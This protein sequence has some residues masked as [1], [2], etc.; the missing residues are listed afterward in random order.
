MLSF[1]T[2]TIRMGLFS[3]LFS[4]RN[5][6]GGDQPAKSGVEDYMSFIRIY[7]QAAMAANLG[8]TNIRLVPELAMF[9]RALKVPTVNN[10]L[11]LGEKAKVRKIMFEQYGMGEDFFDKIDAS[12][13][14]GCKNPQQIQ[15]YTARFQEFLNNLLTMITTLMKWKMQVP[16]FM[17]NSLRTFTHE[18]VHQAMTKASWSKPEMMAT[19]F[20]L[21]KQSESLGFDEAWM[22]EF[23]FNVIV[24]AKKERRK[25]TNA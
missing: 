2:I 13:R 14:K 3:K 22:T 5:A 24:L 7:I 9:K 11:G 17:R 4:K 6:E 20:N 16:S 23:M 12:L 1:K 10:K 25:K 8:I 21:R 18:A 19:A 15:S